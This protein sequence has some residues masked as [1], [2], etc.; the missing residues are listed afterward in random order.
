[1]QAFEE[2]SYILK[3]ADYKE[4]IQNN[5]R[6]YLQF[7][8]FSPEVE[9]IFMKIIHRLLEKNDILYL[10]EML[11]TVIREVITNAVKANTKRL[12]FKMMNLDIRKKEDYRH[13][14]ESFKSDVY[15]SDSDIFSKLKEV[16]LSV[17][18][19]FDYTSDSL[20]I[21]VI[22]NTPILEE[23]QK[24]IE[25]RIK[26][27]YSYNDISEAF[28]DVMDDSEGAGLGL[29]MALMLLKNA[30]FPADAFQ[31]KC[32]SSLTATTLTTPKSTNKD[33]HNIKIADELTKEL[34]KIPSFPE[35]IL[36]IQRLCADNDS[37]IKQISESIKKDPGLTT[38][39]LKL[40]NSAG[41]ITLQTTKTLEDAVKLIGT[42][43]INSLLVASGV[44]KILNSRYKKFES[45]WH[46]SYK[47]AYYAH[48]MSLQ[49]KQTK[50]SEFIY[51]SALL[52]DI[53]QII[54]LSIKPELTKRIHEIAGTKIIENAS[55]LEEM[56]LGVSHSTLGSI[57]CEK[58]GFDES[59][60]TVIKYHHRPHMAP[61]KYRPLIYLIYMAYSLIDIENRRQRFET[62]DEDVLDY[63]HV[64]NK[65]RFEL[66][67]RTLKS[68]YETQYAI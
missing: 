24:K 59:L 54:L 46:E 4:S 11:I 49:T 21:H 8:F 58:W 48:K 43:G 19:M 68:S 53:G 28:E 60:V 50:M 40:A 42:K 36:E 16:S 65:E 25:S 13:G 51:L 3:P 55:L 14:M 17:R 64:N 30:G 39:I 6:F 34:E 57:I 23:E 56:S 15:T 61:E 38:S 9:A 29:I 22:N 45:V 37:T 27:A 44:Q 12:Y 67:Q 47:A 41:Y 31:I 2:Q 5:E 63:Y 20:K 1:L 62:M 18:V 10:K 52:A 66:L 32:E 35:N 7:N 33:Q 26:K